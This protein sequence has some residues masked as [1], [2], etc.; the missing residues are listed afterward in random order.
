[1]SSKVY[2]S[3]LRSRTENSNKVTKLRELFDRAL[4]RDRLPG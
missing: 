3:N 2:F 1:M 4:W